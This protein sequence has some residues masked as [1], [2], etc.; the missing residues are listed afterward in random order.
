[1]SENHSQLLKLGGLAMTLDQVKRGQKVEIDRIPDVLI[2]AQ[3]IRF[4]IGEGSEVICGEVIPAGPIILHRGLQEIA[5]GRRLAQSIKV[6]PV[7]AG[8]QAQERVGAG[9]FSSRS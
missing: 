2:R 3:A 1:M 8:S 9:A 7:S 5:I 6:Q 4:G